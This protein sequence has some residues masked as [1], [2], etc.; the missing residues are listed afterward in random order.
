MTKVQE[1]AKQTPTKTKPQSQE[2]SNDG[3]GAR[4][5]QSI[6]EWRN[7]DGPWFSLCVLDVKGRM[8]VGDV[9]HHGTEPRSEAIFMKPI[10]KPS[11]S[12]GY[13]TFALN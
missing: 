3:P 7:Q 1:K 2:R 9:V 6:K 8:N 5:F 11:T 12:K 10:T 4:A 13:A